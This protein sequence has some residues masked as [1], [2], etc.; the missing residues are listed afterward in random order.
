MK[1]LLDAQ[2]AI[3]HA[4]L[5]TQDEENA[6]AEFY[7][8]RARLG[9]YSARFYPGVREVLGMTWLATAKGDYEEAVKRSKEGRKSKL[10]YYEAELAAF[11]R[12]YPNA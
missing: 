9:E 5:A 12:R 4:G 8:Q 7:Y 11:L 1:D 10:S 2:S 3:L 6:M